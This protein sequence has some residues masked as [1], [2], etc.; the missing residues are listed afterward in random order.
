MSGK[1]EDPEEIMSE[2]RRRFLEK[3]S[4]LK[5]LDT[6]LSSFQ[7]LGQ[8]GNKIIA[9][10]D[11]R[12][13][14]SYFG[15]TRF[16]GGVENPDVGIPLCIGILH[17]D[18]PL[19]VVGSDGREIMNEGNAHSESAFST[20]AL[21]KTAEA[22]SYSLGN[23]K[24]EEGST[25]LKKKFV[26]KLKNYYSKDEVGLI[27]KLSDRIWDVGDP[28]FRAFCKKQVLFSTQSMSSLDLPSSKSDAPEDKNLE[29]RSGFIHQDGKRYSIS[30]YEKKFG[31]IPDSVNP[32]YSTTS[33]RTGG[34]GKPD[35]FV[36]RRKVDDAGQKVDLEL[37]SK[38]ADINSSIREILE[39]DTPINDRTEPELVYEKAFTRTKELAD[40]KTV[41]ESL[42]VV[43]T[44][45]DSDVQRSNWAE[46]GKWRILLEKEFKKTYSRWLEGGEWKMKSIKAPHRS[47]KDG[48]PPPNIRWKLHEEIL[49]IM[50]GELLKSRKDA[51]GEVD[52][53]LVPRKAIERELERRGNSVSPARVSQ[54]MG[55]LHALKIIQKP[56]RLTHG[57][58]RLGYRFNGRRTR[59]I[60]DDEEHYLLER[61][62]DDFGNSD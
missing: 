46:S 52:S 12:T 28:E 16:I 15:W 21:V 38:L 55:D 42:R 60:Q 9:N 40:G 48:G 3:T 39:K 24:T 2:I 36:S 7:T 30:A 22:I 19:V 26:R 27:Y 61:L 31:A 37:K 41:D 20:I 53:L 51:E 13:C 49:S 18:C 57:E 6:E 10:S 14:E 33:E 50:E 43:I 5:D 1:R 58:S 62:L 29:K 4:F 54:I 8:H 32:A 17:R 44:R 47:R 34:Y 45:D 25:A 59:I 35:F 11:R 56:H 23:L